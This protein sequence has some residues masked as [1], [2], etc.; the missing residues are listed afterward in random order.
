MDNWS[1]Y[2]AARTRLYKQLQDSH[3]PNPV[4][5][6]G[7]VHLAFAADLKTDF[8]NPKSEAVAVEFTNTSVTSGGDGS[9]V[10]KNWIRSK[11]TTR[12]SPITALAAAISRAPRRL[13]HGHALPVPSKPRAATGPT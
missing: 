6:S 9:E 5:L 3:A 11:A 1:G 7:D 4:V 10:A 12:T 13:P 8:A 2:P